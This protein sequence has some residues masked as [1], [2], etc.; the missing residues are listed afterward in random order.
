MIVTY[1]AGKTWDRIL[2]RYWPNGK[3]GKSQEETENGEKEGQ[4]QDLIINYGHKKTAIE[5]K[6]TDLHSSLKGKGRGGNLV[7]E[8]R[9]HYLG[10]FDEIWIAI[11]G[12]QS[13][14]DIQTVMSKMWTFR[15]YNIYVKW[16]DSQ[17]AAVHGIRKMLNTAPV[18]LKTP[19]YVNESDAP[20]TLWRMLR[21]FPGMSEAVI[22]DAMN[23]CRREQ[24]YTPETQVNY[25][26][27]R[28][29]RNIDR[30]F[31][32]WWFS[33]IGP[34]DNKLGDGI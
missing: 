9:T 8:L 16:W 2:W 29:K 25:I 19:P 15:Q 12:A 3:R 13:Q 23:H 6:G 4:L 24:H 31:H 30:L 28:T 5:F 14:N 10:K 32:D 17:E 34:K 26:A 11:A 7:L 1:N 22:G 27:K 33:G 20:T 21:Q 18:S